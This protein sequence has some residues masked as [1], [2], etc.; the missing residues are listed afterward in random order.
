MKKLIFVL[1]VIAILLLFAIPA[2]YTAPIVVAQNAPQA[3]ATEGGGRDH[4]YYFAFAAGKG[5]SYPYP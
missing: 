1:I 5:R 2:W 3:T 4:Y